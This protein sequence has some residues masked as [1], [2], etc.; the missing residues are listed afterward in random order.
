MNLDALRDGV[1]ELGWPGVVGIALLVFASALAVSSLYPAFEERGVLREQAERLARR[2]GMGAQEAIRR[3]ASTPEQLAAFYA[4]FPPA[5]A[6]PEWLKK[7]DAVA[8]AKGIQLSTGEYK[9]VRSGT[10]RLARYEITL[11]VQGSY[12]Q[13]RAFIGQVLAEVPSAA[14]EE[15]TLKR[16]A[17]ET[18]RLDARIRLTLFVAL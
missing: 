1:E 8:R 12:P 15:V 5:G 6:T 11:P 9:I 13:I 3:T 17:V 4:F 16:D 18:V 14:V 7:I 10:H 2:H